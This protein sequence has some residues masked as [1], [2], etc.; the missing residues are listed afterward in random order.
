M[1]IR[2][3]QSEHLAG[4]VSLWNG[5]VFRGEV[6]YRPLIPAYFEEKFLIPGA[7]LFVA[8][9]GDSVISFIAGCVKTQ[10]LPGQTSANTP[11][12]LSVLMVDPAHRGRGVGS[13]LLDH[14]EMRMR[15]LGKTLLA[16]TSTCPINLDWIIPGTPGHEHNNM[17][18]ADLFCEGYGFLQRRGFAER[19][20][21]VAMYL[22]LSDYRK[23]PEIEEK[24]AALA[25]EGII[26]GL[27]NPAL[28]CDFDGMCD[29]VGS[30][31]WR[32]VLRDELACDHPRPILAAVHEGKMVGFTGPVDR[33]ENGRGWFT[34]ICTDP[35]YE[36]R[37]IASVLFN[38]LM[39]EFIR[40]GAAY[41]TLFTGTENHAQHLYLKTGF[42]A[43]RQFAIMHKQLEG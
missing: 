31:Y 7:E 5:C 16:I 40:V 32:Q 43:A 39:G 20:R 14:F 17:P 35:L 10:F 29:R 33:Q 34:G 4:V 19:V 36:K 15:E 22:N 27:Y 12:Y 25:A 18:G 37:G 38:D 3:Y 42:R 23:S 30:E 11:G 24:R 21:E 1:E 28:G 41:S 9:E 8:L 26:A 6:L 2:S 13:A